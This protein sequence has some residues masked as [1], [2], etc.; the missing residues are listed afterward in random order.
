MTYSGSPSPKLSRRRIPKTVDAATDVVSN[1]NEDESDDEICDLSPTMSRSSQIF[2]SRRNSF[3]Y[4]S[5][6]DDAPSTALTRSTSLTRYLI[7]ANKINTS[8]FLFQLSW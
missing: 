3:L 6:T 2:S 5:D 7:K 1:L 4:Q 8:Y